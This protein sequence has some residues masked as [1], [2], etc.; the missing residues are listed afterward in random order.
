MMRWRILALLFAARVGLGFQFQT[1]GAV[2][3]ELSGAFGLDHAQIGMMIGVFMAPGLFLALPAGFS[4]R[5]ASDRVLA[6]LCLVALALGGAVS[7]MA[8]G[9]GVIGLG[10]VLA[11]AGFLFASLYF[12]K[13]VAD[14]FEG[15]EI[16]TA[17]SILVMSW[18]FGIAMGQVG[19]TWLTGLYGWRVP[20][21]V[22][23]GLLRGG[24]HFRLRSLSSAARPAIPHR[25]SDQGSFVA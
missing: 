15:R 5:F 7:A 17:M 22:R 6:G 3:G 20:F 23:F 13:M 10:R 9:P 4:G 11:C 8:V 2:S 16:A 19:H 14:W 24:G 1:L 18:P 21:A 25:W 12:T